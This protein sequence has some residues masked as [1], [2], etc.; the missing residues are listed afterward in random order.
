MLSTLHD[1]V[2]ISV[3]ALIAWAI[4]S[5]KVPTGILPTA[6]LGVIGFALVWSLDE[7]HQPQT[8]LDLVIGGLGLMG[9]GMAWRVLRR[10]PSHGRMRRA[11]DWQPTQPP[12]LDADQRR[13]VADG[14]GV[15]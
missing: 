10:G 13:Q 5:P 3:I 15:R 9:C 11:A 14:K 1:L 2:V 12:E 7:W 4:V 8:S 6:G